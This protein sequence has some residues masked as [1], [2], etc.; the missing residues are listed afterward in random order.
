[1]RLILF[2][3]FIFQL[4]LANAQSAQ[5][6]KAN[7]LLAQGKC[8]RASRFLKALYDKDG[9]NPQ[10][11]LH[12]SQALWC[13][14]E[15]S[16]AEAVLAGFIAKGNSQPEIVLE[17]ADMLRMNGNL[18]EAEKM[19]YEFSRLYPKDIR[20]KER[21]KM[22]EQLRML[23]QPNTSYEISNIPENSPASEIN[24]VSSGDIAL[25]LCSNRNRS[26]IRNYKRA[27]PRKK[28]YD[29]YSYA[30]QSKNGPLLT[31]I[32]GNVNT[33]RSESSFTLSSD[34]KEMIFS[35]T[36]RRISSKTKQKTIG[37]YS[38]TWDDKKGWTNVML[39]PFV[40]P[41]F[42][43]MHPS[44]SADGSM[45]FFASD[46]PGGMGQTDLYVCIRIDGVWGDPQHLGR[47]VNTSANEMYPFIARDGTLYFSSD[48][49]LGLGG[50]DIFS[51]TFQNKKYTGVQNLGIP[52]NSPANDFGYFVDETMNNGFFVSDRSNGL[53][54]DDIYRFT[55][56][57]ERYCG[58]ATQEGS[59]IPI[60]GAQVTAVLPNGETFKTG[61]DEKG[62]Y[63]LM[64]PPGL[65]KITINKEG[66]YPASAIL[67]AQPGKPKTPQAF[68]M[69]PTGDIEFVLNVKEKNAG[70]LKDATAFVVDKQTGEII[71]G[72]TDEKGEIKFDLFK[73]REYEVKVA[74]TST[75]DGMYDRF[76]KT[77]STHGFTEPVLTENAEL[78]YYK[79][80]TVFKLPNVYF[81]LN[82]Y[83]LKTSAMR[84]L[85]KLAE[86]M[87]K[88]PDVKIEISAHTDSRGNDTYNLQLSTKRA[89]VC[90][91]YLTTKGVSREN[92]IANGY[93]ETRIL[94][95]C[96]NNVPCTEAEHAVNRR[97][98][99]KIVK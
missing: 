73:N 41:A 76:V 55:R 74:K 63:C 3:S 5:E 97:I 92:L 66:Y 15:K 84:E 71:Q 58:T 81:D 47:I 90:V 37:L 7:R 86:S 93:G 42:N 29:I 83:E 40:Q 2:L 65:Y 16:S 26:T 62:E 22:T 75:A 24:P 11:A 80:E 23:H 59:N 51:A 44:L 30:Q 38:A 46:M 60:N 12:L 43:Y 34:G 35:R 6:R 21:I 14:G 52:V 89:D 4:Y 32:R 36:N 85:D 61:T 56:K 82:S 95:K 33:R 9:S 64:L 50:L 99:F 54:S 28:R 91:Q 69:K 94:N 45:L 88:F 27:T 49:H 77:I 18:A 17:Y 1:M 96:K 53:G 72:K 10:Y 25:M 78:T 87:R 39:L 31:R 67:Q 19:Y 98:E 70:A 79:K 68:R 13:S 57:A 48:G 8:E 20:A